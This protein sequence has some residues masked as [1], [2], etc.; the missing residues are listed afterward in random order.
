MLGELET[1]AIL[2]G[3]SGKNGLSREGNNNNNNTHYRNTPIENSST[4]T[5]RR[6]T[7]R[8]GA[9][10]RPYHAADLE[11]P[12]KTQQQQQQQANI[13]AIVDECYGTS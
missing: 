12:S 4:K 3:L 6:S 13:R 8:S 11:T 9:S 5:G 1:D 7:H 2:Q 10:K